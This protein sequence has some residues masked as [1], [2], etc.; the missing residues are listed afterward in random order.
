MVCDVDLETKQI[1]FTGDNPADQRAAAEKRVTQLTVMM[2]ERSCWTSRQRRKMSR[3]RNI[4]R[5]WLSPNERYWMTRREHREEKRLSAQGYL[6]KEWG[7]ERQV[8]AWRRKAFRQAQKLKRLMIAGGLE[9]WSP[10]LRKRARK[11]ARELFLQ[12]Q[13]G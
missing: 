9:P 13:N 1:R 8:K 10:P 4:L 12:L 5:A 2:K 6:D 3:E 7:S 11:Q